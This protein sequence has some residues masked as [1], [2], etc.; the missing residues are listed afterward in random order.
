ML[1]Y[2]CWNVEPAESVTLRWT[3]LVRETELGYHETLLASRLY[4]SARNSLPIQPAGRMLYITP[5]AYSS[6]V[7]L[8]LLCD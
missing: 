7:V 4:E 3:S 1:W 6:M 8:S 2:L 5:V